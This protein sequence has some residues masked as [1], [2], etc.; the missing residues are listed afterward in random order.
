[1]IKADAGVDGKARCPHRP[2]ILQIESLVGGRCEAG[3]GNG[4]TSHKEVAIL[5]HAEST[6]VRCLDCCTGCGTRNGR[7]TN[8]PIEVD[9]SGIRGLEDVIALRLPEVTKLEAVAPTEVSH[10]IR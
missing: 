7:I 8:T 4:I 10:K 3:V 5:T 1:M 9:H 2:G 6:R